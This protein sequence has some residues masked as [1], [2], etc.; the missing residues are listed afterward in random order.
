MSFIFDAVKA[1]ALMAY[2]TLSDLLHV[3]S[4]PVT[5]VS[6]VVRVTD[7]FA[8][9]GILSGFIFSVTFGLACVAIG[10]LCGRCVKDLLD[11]PIGRFVLVFPWIVDSLAQ[12][13][14]LLMLTKG[15]D[16]FYPMSH[17]GMGGALQFLGLVAVV[18]ARQGT[19]Y[20][21]LLYRGAFL[22]QAVS[23]RYTAATV[24]ESSSVSSVLNFLA[25][26]VA[27]G[28]LIGNTKISKKF[29]ELVDE[30][31]KALDPVVRII[32]THVRCAFALPAR[33]SIVGM[34]S[35][36]VCPPLC[37]VLGAR[38]AGFGVVLVRSPGA[39]A[40]RRTGRDA[41]TCCCCC[42]RCC[43]CGRRRRRCCRCCCCC[44]HC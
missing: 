1:G 28:A 15:E 12:L 17:T 6:F 41:C 24:G 4:R 34:R 36:D 18:P 31:L 43:C 11:A 42:C 9:T 44:C 23:M 16:A 38:R 13:P 32:A 33:L 37:M 25:Y 7:P 20:T 22:Y 27:I 29:R 35:I 5:A 10:A 39:G 30:I 3:A 14:A 40:R 21:H 8:D 26:M 2:D 19:G